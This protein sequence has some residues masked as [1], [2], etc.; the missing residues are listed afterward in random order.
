ML[1]L[2]WLGSSGRRSLRLSG[3]RKAQECLRSASP[4][5][6]SSIC[7]APLFPV[8]A[9][10]L[11][12]LPFFSLLLLFFFFF[13]V[14][15][16]RRVEGHEDARVARTEPEGLTSQDVQFLPRRAANKRFFP[17]ARFFNGYDELFG[18]DR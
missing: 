16:S 12:S 8:H 9:D 4:F 3:P 18:L 10:P 17:L 1:G 14:F 2:C 11:V 6:S 7:A 15:R 13:F 5:F